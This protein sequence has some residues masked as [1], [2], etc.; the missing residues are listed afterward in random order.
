MDHPGPCSNG[1]RATASSY[2]VL[3]VN[4]FQSSGTASPRVRGTNCARCSLPARIASRV[5]QRLTHSCSI[6]AFLKAPEKLSRVLLFGALDSSP[7]CSDGPLGDHPSSP[8]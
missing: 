3:L 7:E 1:T 8:M 6:A 5:F 2:T 4:A